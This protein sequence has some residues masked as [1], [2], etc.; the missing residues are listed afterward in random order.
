M[1]AFRNVANAPKIQSITLQEKTENRSRRYI[2]FETEEIPDAK[3][4]HAGGRI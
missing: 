1:V 4:Q 3:R 2:N